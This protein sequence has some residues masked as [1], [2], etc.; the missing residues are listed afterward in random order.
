MFSL[1]PWKVIFPELS[2][3]DQNPVNNSPFLVTAASVDSPVPLRFCLL[4]PPHKIYEKLMASSSICPDQSGCFMGS[5]LGFCK[6]HTATNVPVFLFKKQQQHL[7]TVYGWQNRDLPRFKNVL[8]FLSPLFSLLPELWKFS[9]YG[10]FGCIFQRDCVDM[11]V[12]FSHKETVGFPC[13]PR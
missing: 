3:S 6:S 11:G 8:T 5:F 2:T 1:K 10:L 4:R 9:L 12:W 13:I 7:I